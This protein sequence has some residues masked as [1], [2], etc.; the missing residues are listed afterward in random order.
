MPLDPEFMQM[1][2]RQGDLAV[3]DQEVERIFRRSRFRSQPSDWL[4]CMASLIASMPSSNHDPAFHFPA[5]A[6]FGC[7]RGHRSAER[8]DLAPPFMKIAQGS[9]T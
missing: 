5:P 6:A 9:L 4:R 8:P 1:P 3:I 2:A 7:P